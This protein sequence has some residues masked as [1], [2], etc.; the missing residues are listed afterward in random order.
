VLDGGNLEFLQ[1]RMSLS[2]EPMS[3]ERL[4]TATCMATLNSLSPPPIKNA[5]E[6]Q[7]QSI[8]ETNESSQSSGGNEKTRE[9]LNRARSDEPEMR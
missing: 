5:E 8:E 6:T 3:D 2:D 4:K 9:K 7:R 1:E